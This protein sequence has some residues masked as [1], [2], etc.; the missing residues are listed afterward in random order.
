MRF[1]MRLLSLVVFVS[2]IFIG[3][4]VYFSNTP[5]QAKTSTQE[6]DLKA[7]SSL[8]SVGQQLVDQ[9]ILREPWSFVLLV[10]V[11]GKAGEVKAGNYLIN[12]GITPYELFVILTNGSNTQSSIT[13]IEGWTFAQMRTALLKNEDIKHV[14]VAYSDEQ[15]MREIGAKESLP[16]G[17]FFPDTYYFS[18]DMTDQAILKRAYFAMQAKLAQAWQT[19]DAGLPYDSPYQALIMASIVEKETGRAAERA[20]I[21]GVFLNRLRIGMRLQT[22]PTVI[23]GLGEHFDGNLHKQDLLRDNSYNTYTRAGLPPT[24]IAMPS[25][26]S[27]EA[28]LHPEKTKA[29]YFVGKGDGTHVFS[30]TLEEHNRA[31]NRYQLKHV[32]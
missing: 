9:G 24:P 8:R 16:E 19:R 28:A 4:M 25:L 14:T 5:L 1:F 32:N 31:V 22:D 7:G 15:L 12:T 30:A 6:V 27:I 21:A 23:Y 29:I 26:A 3:W 13:F 2:L 11:L 17:M 10:R 20:Q 18:R